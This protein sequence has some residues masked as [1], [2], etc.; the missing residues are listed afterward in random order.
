M[1]I[2][3]IP[4]ATKI[5][6]LKAYNDLHLELLKK[7]EKVGP[8]VLLN[9]DIYYLKDIKIYKSYYN[10]LVK[11]YPILC[12][13][14]YLTSLYN[15]TTETEKREYEKEIFKLLKENKLTMNYIE[16]ILSQLK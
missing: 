5:D 1:N 16:F 7:G 14:V 2:D 12:I 3:I 6:I 15:C 13:T 8:T 4:Y 9:E 10:L 11:T